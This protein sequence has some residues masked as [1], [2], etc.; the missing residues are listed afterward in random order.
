MGNL[1]QIRVFRP[2]HHDR[3]HVIL[4]TYGKRLIEDEKAH[5]AY[6]RT[7]DKLMSVEM[8][9]DLTVEL[10][11]AAVANKNAVVPLENQIK[12]LARGAT[13]GKVQLSST[14]VTQMK[15]SAKTI[16]Q[17]AEDN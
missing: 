8:P 17:N 11:K 3:L 12:A 16:I 5:F 4:T 6:E 2:Y 7:N 10:A 9:L 13:T 15:N 1:G 14:L